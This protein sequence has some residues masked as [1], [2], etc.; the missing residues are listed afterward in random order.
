MNYKSIPKK[1]S[2]ISLGKNRLLKMIRRHSP[3][4]KTKTHTTFS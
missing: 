1:K 3:K 4:A 2:T